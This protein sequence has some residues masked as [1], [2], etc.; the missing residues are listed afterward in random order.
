[1]GLV[2]L[3]ERLFKVVVGLCGDV[4]VLKVLLAVECDGLGLHLALLYVDF[5]TAKDDGNVLANTD[6]VTWV[7]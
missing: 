3:Q 1:M 4:V 5:V 7:V 2:N 6:E